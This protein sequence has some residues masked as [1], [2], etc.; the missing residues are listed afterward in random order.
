[1]LFQKAFSLL[2]VI[3]YYLFKTKSNKL[4]FELKYET[5]NILLHHVVYFFS[6]FN[7]QNKAYFKRKADITKSI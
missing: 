4:R 7:L 6:S 2:F 3:K 5:T 1:V